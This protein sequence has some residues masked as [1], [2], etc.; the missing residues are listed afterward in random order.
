MARPAR[1]A[2]ARIAAIGVRRLAG[3]RSRLGPR[4][5]RR[6][7]AILS[8]KRRREFL[9][10]RWLLQRCA[11]AVRFDAAPGGGVRA[12]RRPLAASISHAR[13]W[14]AC[15]IIAGGRIGVDLEPMVERDF[16]AMGKWFFQKSEN[17]T[18]F[19]RR[20][21]R[22]EARVKAGAGQQAG[23][24]EQT[25][26]IGNLA[27]SVCAP[28]GAAL[29]GALL[30]CAAAAHAEPQPLWEVGLGAS[31][32]T[33][34]DYRGSEESRGYLLPLPYLVYR[35]RRVRLDREGAR[36]VLFEGRRVEFNL[37][38]NATP[39]VDSDENRARA[40][41][42]HLDP[43]LEIGPQ[44]KVRL[45]ADPASGTRLEFRLPVRAVIATDFSYAQSVGYVFYPHLSF[46]ARP[47]LGGP[48][49]FGAQ[50]GALF[51]TRKYHQYFYGVD[52]RFATPQRAAYD[53]R[54]GYSGAVAL[55][56][57]SRRFA[58]VWAGGFMRYDYLG[59]AAFEDSPLTRRRGFFMAGVGV[60]YVF[61]ESSEKVEL[62]D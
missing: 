47:H 59:G 13:G 12:V 62:P 39:P 26:R 51:A 49:T 46:G 3:A 29:A 58:R 5:R 56:S 57:L 55:V 9:A 44:V 42:P 14:V 52:Q 8:R 4:D 2:F 25:W 53:A 54:G 6:Y 38:A 18:A 60:A 41:M 23:F 7:T 24:R 50:A 37:S 16:A 45:D 34:P 31:A 22:Y 43:T 11:R 30:A 28:R 19:Y 27:L 20:W 17:K 1:I 61:A 36:V 21:T 48:W 32:L 35:D 15:A 40:G 33:I 10:G